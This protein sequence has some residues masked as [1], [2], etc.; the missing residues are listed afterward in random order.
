MEARRND[1]VLR[2][3]KIQSW[4]SVQT[5]PVR[6]TGWPGCTS[7]NLSLLISGFWV[8]HGLPRTLFGSALTHC[9]VHLWAFGCQ[10][11]SIEKTCALV[12]VCFDHF[13][14]GKTM[15]AVHRKLR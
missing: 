3:V 2:I 13:K 7:N 9:K 1:I 4:F 11:K 10:S 15:Q 14:M 5:G 6:G 12:P 8:S